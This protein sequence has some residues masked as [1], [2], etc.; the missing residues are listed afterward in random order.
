M[1]STPEIYSRKHNPDIDRLNT[2]YDILI[3]KGRVV[4]N[5][6]IALRVENSVTFTILSCNISMFQAGQPLPVVKDFF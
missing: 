3:I 1:V 2:T 4:F 5:E 6:P